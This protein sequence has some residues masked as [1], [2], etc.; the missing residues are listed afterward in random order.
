MSGIGRERAWVLG[1]C[2][3]LALAPMSVRAQGP[4]QRLLVLP[5]VPLS[6]SEG[7]REISA[8]LSEQIQTSLKE[9]K[10]LRVLKGPGPQDQPEQQKKAFQE[11]R[12]LQK[13]AQQAY[14]RLH[15]E[16]SSRL[17]G[18]ALQ[19]YHR[20][21]VA[22]ADL[23][24]LTDCLLM[25]AVC[26]YQLGQ[27]DEGGRALIQLFA[28]APQLVLSAQRFPPAFRQSAAEIRRQVKEKPRGELEVVSQEEG[29][30]VRVDG[31]DPYPVPSVIRDLIPGEHIL[32]VEKDGHSPWME[33]VGV[34]GAQRKRARVSP[35]P[36]KRVTALISEILALVRFNRVR[37]ELVD[38]IQSLSIDR[39]AEL[40][41]VGAVQQRG[42]RFV[43][44]SLLFSAARGELCPLP[45]LEL[46][47]QG[48]NLQQGAGR[49]VSALTL[50]QERCTEPIREGATPALVA[51]VRAPSASGPASPPAG[52]APAESPPPGT[53][54]DES[55]GGLLS[56]VVLP[57]GDPGPIPATEPPPPGERGELKKSGPVWYTTWWFWTL[58]G[59]GVG[60]LVAVGTFD[61]DVTSASLHVKWAGPE[62]EQP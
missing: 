18:R 22:L 1:T 35:G 38:R 2:A 9:Q 10:N 60:A 17:Y 3:L 58:V 44:G 13:K 45:T 16:E 31:G 5:Y 32:R 34:M 48:A 55:P 53:A 50:A 52:E 47:A 23:T 40:L 20:A 42:D 56:D 43:V 37:P 25:I 39:S 62:G 15:L 54:T 29:C 51:E 57:G 14:D 6:G 41:L 8:Q 12:R 59:V 49:L 33:R 19:S 61:R 46:E 21:L 11:G 24:P 30:T 28:L 4:E 36:A 27:E 7:E 26:H